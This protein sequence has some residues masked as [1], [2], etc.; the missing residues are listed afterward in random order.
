MNLP[1]SLTEIPESAFE[2]CTKLKKVEFE[3]NSNLR[4]IGSYCFSGSRSLT[5][6]V[7]PKKVT[8]IK[9]YSFH[10]CKK[11]K[12]I[13]FQSAMPRIEKAAFQKIHDKAVFQVPKKYKSS[14]RKKLKTKAWYQP[15]M[16]VR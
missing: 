13:T 9:S 14:Y 3:K 10:E 6:I 2:W 16:R 7:I 8:T 12:K 5:E 15:T 11:L 1:D 4:G